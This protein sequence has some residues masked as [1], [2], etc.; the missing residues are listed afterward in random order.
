M[1]VLAWSLAILI[2]GSPTNIPPLDPNLLFG[3]SVVWLFGCLVVQLFGGIAKQGTGTVWYQVVC[4]H[5]IG[6]TVSVN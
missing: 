5:Y 3:C 4:D 2:D 6:M 1:L